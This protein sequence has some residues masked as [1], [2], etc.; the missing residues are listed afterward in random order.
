MES[1]IKDLNTSEETVTDYKS[2]PF[3]FRFRSNNSTKEKVCQN[4]QT[5]A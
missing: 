1:K 4:I 3:L 2:L 5:L